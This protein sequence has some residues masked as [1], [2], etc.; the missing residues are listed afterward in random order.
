MLACCICKNA[1]RGGYER[2]PRW[3]QAQAEEDKGRAA[4]A[5]AGA[6]AAAEAAAAAFD[7]FTARCRR[8]TSA[9]V[10]D[11]HVAVTLTM[12]HYEEAHRMR[13]D[14]GARTSAFERLGAALRDKAAPLLKGLGGDLEADFAALGLAADGENSSLPG[15]A[16]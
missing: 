13:E 9:A 12:K 6:T 16:A 8:E 15:N 7:E 11:L 2:V 5:L 10:H 1:A 3:L 4:D 14:F